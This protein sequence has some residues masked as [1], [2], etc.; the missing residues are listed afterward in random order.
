MH[1][2]CERAKSKSHKHQST[3]DE[4]D[5]RNLTLRRLVAQCNK[6]RSSAL[7]R[8]TERPTDQ[9]PN[10]HRSLLD[11]GQRSYVGGKHVI[12]KNV[13]GAN[14]MRPS[15]V[16]ED[17]GVGHNP[18]RGLHPLQRPRARSP[19]RNSIFS[20]SASWWIHPGQPRRACPVQ[21]MSNHTGVSKMRQ[22]Q[23][24][25]HRPIQER[26]DH[27]CC[28]LK[29]RTQNS[30]FPSVRAAILTHYPHFP[31]IRPSLTASLS[32]NGFAGVSDAQGAVGERHTARCAAATAAGLFPA[33]PS[34]FL[35]SCR[36]RRHYPPST[37][38]DVCAQVQG[39]IQKAGAEYGR[40]YRL[41]VRWP[42]S[43]ECPSR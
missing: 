38:Y 32:H 6:A 21:G 11:A 31:A 30:I 9:R 7:D 40:C 35:L 20:G 19:G 16:Y 12:Q 1:Q 43:L 18:E 3:I 42:Q 27:K 29:W 22:I 33:R 23:S 41:R 4:S 15:V 13:C 25:S 24:A 5:R 26:F 34:I 28:G 8:M 10:A 14:H 17:S 36:R 39:R 2:T 37:K